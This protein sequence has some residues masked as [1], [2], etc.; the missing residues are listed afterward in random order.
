V[1]RTCN[2]TIVVGN[3]W[4]SNTFTIT[5]HEWEHVG[6]KYIYDI[7]NIDLFLSNQEFKF[8]YNDYFTGLM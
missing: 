4:D 6:P 2:I 3:V 7:S 1:E 5:I 8:D